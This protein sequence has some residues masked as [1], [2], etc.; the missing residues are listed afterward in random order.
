VNPGGAVTVR[1]TPRQSANVTDSHVMQGDDEHERVE[2]PAPSTTSTSQSSGMK[3]H[4]VF[5]LGAGMFGVSGEANIKGPPMS[6]LS[7]KDPG[8]VTEVSRPGLDAP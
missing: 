3:S 4:A 2:S 6:A 5:S 7:A 8:V 1:T